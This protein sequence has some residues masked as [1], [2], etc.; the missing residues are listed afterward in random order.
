MREG[1]EKRI[2]KLTSKERGQ[3]REM[4]KDHTQD[5]HHRTVIITH[6]VPLDFKQPPPL[7]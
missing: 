7:P 4:E 1:K 3:W 6:A 2:L 5:L